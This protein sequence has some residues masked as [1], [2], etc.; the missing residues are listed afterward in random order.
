MEGAPGD[1]AW[2]RNLSYEAPDGGAS[3]SSMSGPS[4][5]SW[6]WMPVSCETQPSGSPSAGASVWWRMTCSFFSEAF[7]TDTSCPGWTASVSAPSLRRGS[8]AGTSAVRGIV[9]T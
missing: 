7:I 6:L 3:S 2:G 9:S 5:G 8:S 1:G 4:A